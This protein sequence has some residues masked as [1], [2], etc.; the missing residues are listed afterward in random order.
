MIHAPF[1]ALITYPHVSNVFS[2]LFV[3][4]ETS[5]LHYSL[6]QCMIQY[7]MVTQA[8]VEFELTYCPPDGVS[9]A[10]SSFS[11][12]QIDLDQQMLMDIEQNI[13]NLERS[14]CQGRRGS[15]QSAVGATSR[16]HKVSL[17]RG[18]SLSAPEKTETSPAMEKKR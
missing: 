14:M 3:L 4:L 16:G 2:S 12:Q 1:S 9:A 7:E 11:A 18:G 5:T 8:T 15:W 6:L 10:G 13:A 17:Q